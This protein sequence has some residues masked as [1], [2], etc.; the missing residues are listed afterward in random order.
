MIDLKFLRENPDIVKENI[1]KKFQD[2]KLPL[3][4][5]VIELDEQ[6]RSA[7]QEADA[8]RANRN[9]ISKQIGALMGQ[10]KKDEAMAL[11]E[12]VSKDAARLAELEEQEKDLQEKITR[13]MMTIPNI[14]DPSV[15]IGKDDSCNV[16]SHPSFRE[17]FGRYLA[18]SS[19]FTFT[20]SIRSARLKSC[21]SQICSPVGTIPR[22]N[23]LPIIFSM[24]RIFPFSRLC[25]MATET[26]DFPALPVRPLRCV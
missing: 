25:T 7:Q 17:M 21:F 10:G 6:A 2:H 5:E 4:D 23:F 16:V 14:I 11:K 12:Q 24:A 8:L 19:S 22:S 3:V 26:P 9:S 1:K 18:I 13:I 15:P 20:F